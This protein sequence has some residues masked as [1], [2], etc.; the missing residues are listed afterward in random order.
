[1][2]LR[3]RTSSLSGGRDIDIKTLTGLETYLKEP[4]DIM[5]II[6]DM[7]LDPSHGVPIKLQAYW[8]KNILTAELIVLP[9]SISTIYKVCYL[10]PAEYISAQTA[11]KIVWDFIIRFR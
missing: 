2:Q 3:T 5:S 8:E 1:M 11:M 10:P 4:F 6:F 9:C 7:Y